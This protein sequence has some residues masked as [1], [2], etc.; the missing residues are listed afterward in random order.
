[1]KKRAIIYILIG[2]LLLILGL[3]FV[4]DDIISI[5][6]L[7]IGAAGALIFPGFLMLSSNNKDERKN[8]KIL[9]QKPYASNS[10]LG[11]LLACIDITITAIDEALEK[12][13][14][15]AYKKNTSRLDYSIY[16]FFKSY[17]IICSAQNEA[18]AEAFSTYFLDRLKE[19]YLPILSESRIDN[20]IDTRLVE[21]QKII[22]TS[23]TTK[24]LSESLCCA[25]EQHII[26][27]LWFPDLALDDIAIA[28]PSNQLEVTLE[29]ASMNDYIFTKVGKM[30]DELIVKWDNSI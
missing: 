11:S 5:A 30:Y 18:L 10:P 2:T 28:D 3:V 14:K 7:F 15:H 19:H 22:H 23:E 29:I 20:I 8:K 13:S 26:K 21:Y 12:N 4:Y 9:F 27:D 6:V 17:C 24:E 16:W 25:I 1:M